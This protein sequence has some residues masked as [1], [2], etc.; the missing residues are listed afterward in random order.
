MRAL[1]ASSLAA[2]ALLC[3]STTLVA[4][5]TPQRPPRPEAQL[6]AMKKLAYMA[7]EWKGSGWMDFGGRRLT[8]TGSERVQMKLDGLA[9]LVEGA[10]FSRPEGATADVPVHTTLAVIS[11][12]PAAK[13]YRFNT[14]LAQGTSGEHELVVAENGWSWQ[15]THP[16]GTTRYTMSRPAEDEWLEIG[17][18]LAAD[19]KSWQKFFEMRLT[20]Q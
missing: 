18:R 13:K 17:E 7:G 14:W 16:R 1:R 6:A 15:L 10:F 5:E 19:G 2:V 8:F 20:K 4:E 3:I 12:D 11:F 9:L